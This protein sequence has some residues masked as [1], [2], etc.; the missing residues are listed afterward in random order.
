MDFPRS[1]LPSRLNEGD[2]VSLDKPTPSRWVIGKPVNT[3]SYQSDERRF[4]SY[5]HMS[6]MSTRTKLPSPET[7]QNSPP[8][9]LDAYKYLTAKHSRNTPKLLAYKRR[10]QLIEGPVPG[11]HVTWI[12]WE[13]VP[14]KCLGCPRY[15]F[16]YWDMPSDERKRVREAFLQEF[17]TIWEMGYFPFRPSP[18][19]MIWDN[20]TGSLYFVGFRDSTHFQPNNQSR[21]PLK[22]WLPD[23]DLA[24]PPQKNFKWRIDY[25]E[26]MA[27]WKL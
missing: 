2:E 11:G 8:P 16:V 12:V 20:N 22:A 13:K 21:K 26:N 10:T 25:T 1:W 24:R 5:F 4:N 19:S 14:G 7:Q 15:A 3:H 17:P 9:E 18:A 27:G 6:A 23:F